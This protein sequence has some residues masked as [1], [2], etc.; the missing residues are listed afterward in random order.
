[1][2]LKNPNLNLTILRIVA[3]NNTLFFHLIQKYN[4]T[5]HTRAWIGKN[6]KG[7]ILNINLTKQTLQIMFFSHEGRYTG[8]GQLGQDIPLFL[9]PTNATL[10]CTEPTKLGNFLKPST[11]LATNTGATTINNRDNTPP[12]EL[13]LNI[14]F[15]YSPEVVK[16]YT[17]LLQLIADNNA[18]CAVAAGIFSENSPKYKVKVV[19]LG[20]I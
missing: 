19:N 14:L 6:L 15:V 20:L 16:S 4:I 10:E 3:P 9:S 13:T 12:N 1:M 11:N 7:E 2:L 5:L 8:K 17:S 18:L